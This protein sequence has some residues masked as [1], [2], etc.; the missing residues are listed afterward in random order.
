MKLNKALLILLLAFNLSADSK[1]FSLRFAYGKESDQDLGEI[2]TFQSPT[3]S[4]YDFYVYAIDVGYRFAKNTWDLPLDF[5]IKGGTA[6]FKTEDL[7][8]YPEL[9]GIA[10]VSSKDVYEFTFYIKAYYKFLNNSI[11]L[12]LGEGGSYITDYLAH[13]VIEEN[14]QEPNDPTYAKYLNYLDIS[15]DINLG[16][17][18]NYKSLDETYLGYTIK[19]RSGIFGLINGVSGGSNYNT[20]SIERNF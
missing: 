15:L 18:F 3:K 17:I 8:K 14:E 7:S 16:K 5:Y 4:K 6:I 2:L 19:H 1:N 10:D 13:E 20:I 12:G 9:D 11:R